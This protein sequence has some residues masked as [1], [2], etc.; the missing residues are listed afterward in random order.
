MLGIVYFGGTLPA[1]SDTAIKAATFAGVIIGQVSFGILADVVG[2]K[3]MY[4]L[5]LIIII[6]VTLAQSLSSNSPAMSIVGLMIFW[7][8]LMVSQSAPGITMRVR[9]LSIRVGHRHRRGLPPIC[10]N[11]LG[12]RYNKME[13]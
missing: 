8:V 6:I 1:E 4:G 13:R 9:L 11:H 7:R 5:E 12:V 10:D 3:S 2:R